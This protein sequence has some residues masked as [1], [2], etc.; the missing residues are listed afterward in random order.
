MVI[1]KNGEE[2]KKSKFGTER[3]QEC[4]KESA[5]KAYDWN[6]RPTAPANN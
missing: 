5:R 1:E 3:E 2:G 6:C 4:R